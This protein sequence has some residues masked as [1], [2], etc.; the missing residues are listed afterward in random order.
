Y[1]GEL[2][3]ETV[4][5]S[6]VTVQTIDENRRVRRVAI[7]QFLRRQLCIRPTLVVPIAASD[8]SSFGKLRDK[9]ADA[10]GKFLWP[11]RVA[12]THTGALKSAGHEM[13][14]CIVEAGLDELA[15]RI[16]YFGVG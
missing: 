16:D 5:Q 3:C 10:L 11:I 7:D 8:L 14:V 9:I 1:A 12:E 2:Q 15:F 13:H 4:C 6:H